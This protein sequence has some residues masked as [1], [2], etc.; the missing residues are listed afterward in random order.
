MIATVAN[1]LGIRDPGDGPL[2]EKIAG[3]LGRT[4]RAARA[5]QRRAGRRCGARAERAAG[6]D[7][8]R[9]CSPR[10]ASC[11]GSAGSR[12]SRSGRS[13]PD[14]GSELFVERARAVKPDFEV[15]AENAGAGRRDLRR[16]STTSPLALELAAARLRV[17]TPAALVERLDHALPVLVGGA[18]DLPE[19]QRTLRADHR[20][21]RPAAHGA[22]ARTAPPPRGVPRG[23]RPRRGRVDVRRAARRPTPWSPSAPSSTAAS[24]ASR[25]ADRGPTSPC[26]PRCAST[27][28]TSLEERG[29]LAEAQ[30][31][32]C[33]LLRRA[34]RRR[35]LR[36]DLAGT[37]RARLAPRRRA[38]RA[39]GHGRPPLRDG[40]GRRRR[41]AGVAALLVLV[42]RRPGRRRRRL[43]DAAARARR[44][45]LGSGRAP[46][47]ST[48]STRSATGRRRMPRSCR[49]W[50]MRRLLPPRRR[51]ARRV[52]GPRVALRRPVRTGSARASTR[53][54]RTP[55]WPSTSPTSS[56]TP[57]AGRW[58]GSCSAGSALAQGRSTTPSQQFERAWPLARS[59]DDTLG[60]AIGSATSAGRAC[61]AASPRARASASASSCSSPSTIG[62]DE[63]IADAFEG[64]FA[65][66]STAGDLELGGRLLGAAEDIRER[67]GLGTRA[68]LL[69]LPAVPRARA[70]RA[71]RVALRAGAPDRTR[72]RTRRHRRGRARLTGAANGR[73]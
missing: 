28:A 68:P 32:A 1:A 57:S 15:T 65:V 34:R 49:P 72:R 71:R 52:P 51:L 3:A 50:P 38:R 42:G 59:I 17:L 70:G 22:R 5:R 63:G 56:T 2:T 55:G 30:A 19:R 9:R 25:I 20:L 43:D 39:A 67:K 53:R 11:S 12:T 27:A 47:R 41:G 60:E 18:R 48:A 37:G 4:A 14:A 13:G 33:G 21:E 64:L 36:P 44:R 45:A 7:R 8:P 46:S 24:C 58:S 54:R 26:S 31:A 6:G 69:V 23:L 61:S 29:L 62:H 10:A 40:P 16:R 35:R 66:A 73:R